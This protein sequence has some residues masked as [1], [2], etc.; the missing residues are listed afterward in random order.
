[1]PQNVK[2]FMLYVD[3]YSPIESLS[4]AQKG[5]LLEA[6]FAW[7]MD[8]DY[9]FTDPVVQMAFSFFKQSFQRDRER[10]EAKCAK[11][12]ESI[13]KRWNTNEYERKQTDTTGY[14][15]ILKQELKQEQDKSIKNTKVF[16]SI[17]DEIDPSAQPEQMELVP[18]APKANGV[19]SCPQQ[20]ILEVYRE[21]LPQLRQP[22]ILRAN[23]QSSIKARWTEK[24][25]EGKFTNSEEGV[26]FFRRVFRYV[27]QNAFLTGRKTNFKAD[28]EWLVKA[29]NWDKV[30]TGKYAEDDG[31]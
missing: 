29:A 2:G 23:V 21:E 24:Y 22:R 19:P 5:E 3:Q 4:K 11:A 28:L 6:F 27:G 9:E 13:S 8:E 15:P 17:S 7:N 10:Y 20:R 12:K 1:M 18:V 25:R 31:R 30:T 14:E 16:S 26:E